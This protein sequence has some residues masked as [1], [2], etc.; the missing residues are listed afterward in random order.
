MQLL[1]ISSFTSIQLCEAINQSKKARSSGQFWVVGRTRNIKFTVHG[2]N[3]KFFNDI[4]NRA[5]FFLMLYL[6]DMD[7]NTVQSLKASQYKGV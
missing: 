3:R 1:L 7:Y 2:L 6:Y 4:I 5:T